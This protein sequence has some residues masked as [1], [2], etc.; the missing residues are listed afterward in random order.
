M[1]NYLAAVADATRR[2]N[3]PVPDRKDFLAIL[4]GNPS[5]LKKHGVVADALPKSFPKVKAWCGLQCERCPSCPCLESHITVSSSVRFP[6]SSLDREAA[7]SGIGINRT[8][9]RLF[10]CQE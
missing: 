2:F 6:K 3:C 5:A 9:N 4:D 1:L 10:A 7:L 8:E